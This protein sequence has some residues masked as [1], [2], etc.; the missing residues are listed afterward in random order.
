MEEILKKLKMKLELNGCEVAAKNAEI[1]YHFI[2]NTPFI[3]FGIRSLGDF[4]SVWMDKGQ[5][6]YTTEEGTNM[7]GTIDQI[8]GFIKAIKD[9]QY[10]QYE[11]L[12]VR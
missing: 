6:T 12:C 8:A 11:N 7:A 5:L 1:V 2:E 4:E 3:V 10:H 9:S